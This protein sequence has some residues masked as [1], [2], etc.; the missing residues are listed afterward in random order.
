LLSITV[1]FLSVCWNIENRAAEFSGQRSKKF[2]INAAA[3]GDGGHE[4]GQLA[5]DLHHG[6]FAIDE[7]TVRSYHGAIDE[8]FAPTKYKNLN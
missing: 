7:Q 2:A 8:V 4:P 6:Q 3:P 1:S 5:L